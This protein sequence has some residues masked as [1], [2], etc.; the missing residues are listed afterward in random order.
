MPINGTVDLLHPSRN[1]HETDTH[2]RRTSTCKW[3]S[4]I[5]RPSE[6][7]AEPQP[8]QPGALDRE[9]SGGTHAGGQ[10]AGTLRPSGRNDDSL[11]IS[12]RT[13]GVGIGGTPLGS[14]GFEGGAASSEPDQEGNGERP[15]LAGSRTAGAA[16]A[17]ARGTDRWS[18]CVCERARGTN[19]GGGVSEAVGA[20]GGG[21]NGGLSRASPYASAWLRLQAGERRPRYES[22]PARLGAQEYS[23]HGALYGI[24]GRAIQGVLG[25]LNKMEEK[26]AS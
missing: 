3:D 8:P 19:L 16:E 20:D 10:G 4:S 15:S 22:D 21:I 11:G 7:G 18:V 26:N 5:R 17:G 2:E 25:G 24:I 1:P 9:G 23:A 14:G 12:A 6:T 13:P